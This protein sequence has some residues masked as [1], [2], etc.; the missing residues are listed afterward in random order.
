M[1]TVSYVLYDDTEQFDDIELQTG[2]NENEISHAGTEENGG[3]HAGE[4]VSPPE[5]KAGAFRIEDRHITA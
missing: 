2:I 4:S 3:R 5:L 1:L